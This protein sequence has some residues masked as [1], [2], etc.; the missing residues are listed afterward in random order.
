MTDSGAAKGGGSQA[1]VVRLP[2]QR[3]A[4]DASRAELEALDELREALDELRREIRLRLPGTGAGD[5]GFSP[6]PGPPDV[7]AL[8]DELRAR[9][10]HVGMRERSGEVDEFGME[11]DLVERLG[12][13]QDFLAERYWR[14]EVR[15]AEFVPASGPALYIVNRS[16]LLPYDGWILA[17]LVARIA[18][19]GRRP[20]FMVEEELIA[21]PFLQPALVRSGGVL[22]CRENAERLLDRG[23]SL[24]VFPEGMRGAIKTFDQRYE[25]QGFGHYALLEA[26][27]DAG[28]P[29]IPVGVVG[30][31]EA[32]PMLFRSYL[33]ARLLGLPFLPVTPTF[34]LLG[35]AGL[36]PLPSRWGVGFGAPLASAELD[37]ADGQRPGGVMGVLRDHV[38]ELVR[39]GRELR[40][41]PW[42]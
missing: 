3:P 16:G 22:A 1:K 40:P 11:F 7:F 30:G 35:P 26:A 29:V 19:E 25:L 12:P 39:V 14:I 27:L 38:E 5:A 23:D 31:E 21:L 20:R 42:G 24:A 2:V 8:F 37:R 33:L 10:G 6:M 13:L 4:P 9:L 41:S 15:G 32:Q 36:L 34:P 17:H 18:G 28:V